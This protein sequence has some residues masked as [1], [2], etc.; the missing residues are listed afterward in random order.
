MSI[1][2]NAFRHN[3]K[4]MAFNHIKSEPIL[5][6]DDKVN[7]ILVLVIPIVILRCITE[8]AL[9]VDISSIVIYLGI[10]IDLPWHHLALKIESFS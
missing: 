8:S 5:F 2:M 4:N 1:A 6:V 3:I 10:S 7:L 9:A